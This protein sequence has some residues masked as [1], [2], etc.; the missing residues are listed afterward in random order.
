MNGHNFNYLIYK[1]KK[2]RKNPPTKEK[3]K[4][5]VIGNTNVGKSTFINKLINRSDNYHKAKPKIHKSENSI[6]ENIA[7][8]TELSIKHSQL[9]SSVLAGTTVGVTKI[10]DIHLG[11]KVSLFN[12]KF[13]P[14]IESILVNLIFIIQKL[15]ILLI[16]S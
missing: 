12:I 13:I 7:E 2:I 5:Y 11:V 6:A 10:E 8:L 15:L 14:K 1:L 9:T 4:I 16:K 3:P